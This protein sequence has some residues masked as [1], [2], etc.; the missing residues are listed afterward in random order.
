MQSCEDDDPSNSLGRHALKNI[1]CDLLG[2]VVVGVFENGPDR[3][4]RV[5]H[6]SGTGYLAWNPFNVLAFRPVD[7]FHV[8]LGAGGVYRTIGGVRKCVRNLAL[9]TH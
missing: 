8:S 3:Q 2:R 9:P 5:F 4:A 1:V 6:Q 7:V